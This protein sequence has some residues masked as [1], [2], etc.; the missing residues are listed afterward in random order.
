MAEVLSDFP[1]FYSGL[2]RFLDGQVW[3]LPPNEVG[4]SASVKRTALTSA[5]RRRG[6]RIRTLVTPEGGL[7]VQAYGHGITSA[8]DVSSD[9]A[10]MST[11]FARLP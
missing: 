9:T 4:K 2:N 5:A 11:H 6:L 3:H 7:I 1:A 8:G 10:N